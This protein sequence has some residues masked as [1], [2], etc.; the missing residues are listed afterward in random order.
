ML[1]LKKYKDVIWGSVLVVIALLVFFYLS[2]DSISINKTEIT[3]TVPD[4]PVKKVTPTSHS[5]NIP[6]F[7]KYLDQG[8]FDIYIKSYS[9]LF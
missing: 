5:I 3:Q 1:R 6:L 8:Q 9:L 2:G 4:I 7:E